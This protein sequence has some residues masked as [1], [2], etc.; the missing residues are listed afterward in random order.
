MDFEDLKGLFPLLIFIL[1][2]VIDKSSRRKRKKERG[3]FP[4]LP[5]I[6]QPQEALRQSAKPAKCMRKPRSPKSRKK[7]FRGMWSSPKIKKQNSRAGFTT[8]SLKSRKP[9]RFT[10]NRCLC[11]SRRRQ[12]LNLW[13]PCLPPNPKSRC[14]TVT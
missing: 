5:D 9:S 14:L 6:E 1:T 2:I 8:N 13:L 12:R 11:L 10:R 3:H 7:K 4:P